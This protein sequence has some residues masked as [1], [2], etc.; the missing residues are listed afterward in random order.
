MTSLMTNPAFAAYSIAC[1]ILV[2][3]MILTG[4]LTA[5]TRSR[6]KQFLNPEDA[7]V[8][9]GT[10]AV[11]EHADVQRLL[12]M[13]RNDLENILPFFTVGLIFV[14]MGAPAR[15]STIYFYTFTAA[16]IVHSITYLLQLQPWRTVAFVVGVLCVVGM[17]V[18]ILIAAL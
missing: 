10:S 3:K 7:R 1:S 14:L 13:H 8:L 11:A 17:L 12:R 9:G 16:R 4:L 5:A 6:V 2:F 15:T 18:Q